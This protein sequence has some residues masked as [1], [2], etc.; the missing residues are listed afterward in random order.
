V[1]MSKLRL[2]EDYGPEN[3]YGGRYAK[4]YQQ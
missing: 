3:Y 4:Y 2:Y 1:A